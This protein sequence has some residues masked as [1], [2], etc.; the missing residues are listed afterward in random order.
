MQRQHLARVE[1]KADP[2]YSANL[3]AK[4]VVVPDDVFQL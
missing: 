3:L 2:V 4:T 1:N